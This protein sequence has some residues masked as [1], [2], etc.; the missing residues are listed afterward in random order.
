MRV[1]MPV[2]SPRPNKRAPARPHAG[3][4]KDKFQEHGCVDH[5]PR[6]HHYY[7]HYHR[8]G[9]G[10]PVCSAIY[11]TVLIVVF[12]VIIGSTS[13]F[14]HL[15]YYAP[16]IGI[17]IFVAVSGIVAAIVTSA[18]RKSQLQA[19]PTGTIGSPQGYPQ[20]GGYP[21]QGYPQQGAYPPASPAGAAAPQPGAYGPTTFQSV[22]Q[23]RP[24]GIPQPQ[25]RFQPPAQATAS[26]SRFCKSCG[27]PAGSDD[28][29]FCS[30]CG[31]E[32]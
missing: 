22:P 4:G 2:R 19:Q 10:N 27:M 31:A 26:P 25:P 14:S 32:L 5:M 28:E 12:L 1:M 11:C 21:P 8:H 30:N 23:P 16:F 18:R 9:R 29:R 3:R 6:H 17:I 15:Y 13:G 24:V 7:H 20:Q